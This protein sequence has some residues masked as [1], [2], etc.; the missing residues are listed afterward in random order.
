MKRMISLLLAAML[1]SSCGTA[2]YAE[3]LSESHKTTGTENEQ[4]SNET[5]YYTVGGVVVGLAVLCSLVS[6]AR[7]VCLKPF[8]SADSHKKAVKD[9]VEKL[10]DGKSGEELTK[11]EEQAE[12]LYKSIGLNKDGT[13][14]LT[15]DDA[16]EVKDGIFFT[17]YDK[18]IGKLVRKV[19]EKKSSSADQQTDE[20]S[21]AQTTTENTGGDQS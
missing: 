8:R 12:K 21:E 7:R 3:S 4:E 16:V 11:A 20:T 18:T 2:P 1:A 6:G 10:K 15:G 19:K 17:A 5:T 13:T 14:S 9:A